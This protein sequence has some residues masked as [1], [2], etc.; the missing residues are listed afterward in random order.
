[1]KMTVRFEVHGST[2]EDV[3][4]TAVEAVSRLPTR[5][6]QEWRMDLDITEV[7]AANNGNI[8]VWRGEVEARRDG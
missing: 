3:E 7:A 5:E 4:R 6:G 2:V 1:M 8:V